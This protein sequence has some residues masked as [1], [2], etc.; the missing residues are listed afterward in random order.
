MNLFQEAD[1]RISVIIPVKNGE[2]TLRRCLESIQSAHGIL[3]EIIVVDDASSDHSAEI[4]REMGCRVFQNTVSKGAAFSRNEG[5]RHATGDILFFTDS[6]IEV[7]PDCFERI[8]HYF[9]SKEAE[10]MIGLLSEHAEYG[11]F[12]SRYENYY[13]HRQY[14]IHDSQ[15]SIFYTSAAAIR[16]DL[17]LKQS[18][19]DA[20]YRGASI[21]DMEFG[22]RLTQQGHKILID[23][24]LQVAHLKEF[25]V[26]KL[27]QTNFHKAAGTMKIR[28]RNRKSGIRGPDL[29][30]PPQ[31]FVLGI[32]LTALMLALWGIGLAFGSAPVALAGFICPII[33]WILNFSWP[34]YLAASAGA[35]FAVRGALFMILN[36][37][38]YGTGI[39]WAFVSFARGDRY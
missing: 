26:W 1:L 35:G 24:F 3:S 17:F 13:M 4:A 8:E 7:P 11:S 20:N 28:L 12:A 29:V 39:I 10:A 6:D 14:A 18:G 15:I 31:A 27:L 5:A 37:I 16:R 21:E 33:I 22:Q 25:T 34:A 9:A 19:F 36:Y 32:P 30:A 2:R 38:A 23:K